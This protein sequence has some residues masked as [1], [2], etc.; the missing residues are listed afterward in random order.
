MN[1]GYLY[2]F[3]SYPPR[4]SGSRIYVYQLTQKLTQFGCN[5][6]TFDYE[7]NPNCITYPINSKGIQ[8]FLDNIDVLYLRID[9][10]LLF[11]NKLY[12]KCIEKA[13][14]VSKPMCWG[15][16]AP[17][18]ERQWFGVSFTKMFKYTTM[19]S[20]LLGRL[21]H[22]VNKIFLQPVIRK[23]DYCRRRYRQYVNTAICLSYALKDYAMSCLGIKKCE[24]IPT[25]SDPILFSPDKK[26]ANLF[27]NYSDYFKVIYVSSGYPWHGFNFIN[28]L[29]KMA[30]QN[31]HK[32]LFIVLDSLPKKFDFVRTKKNLLV[33]K[34]VD[35]FDVPAYLASA[36]ICLCLYQDHSWLRYGF[37]MSPL[38]LFDYMASAKPI[39][40]SR[41]GQISAI[42]KDG[43]NGLLTNNEINDIYE[44]ILFCI[45]HKD[46]AKQMG[47][48]AR[49]E[50]INCY[51]WERVAKETLE[52]FKSVVSRYKSKTKV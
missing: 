24:I 18:E 50:V 37:Y 43:K 46:K 10:C 11:K 27:Q 4:K 6:H 15:I 26:D 22:K 2:N 14:S 40:A 16:H 47:N 9:G 29:A 51:N 44:K 36:D 17:A 39:I 23:E 7:K 48:F 42:I 19:C 38:K 12:L 35:Y 52:V 8:T 28:R 49:N 13:I 45:K 21:E 34:C 3:N 30:H 20:G 31:R 33:F 5:I 1:V 32:I 25:G 41:M